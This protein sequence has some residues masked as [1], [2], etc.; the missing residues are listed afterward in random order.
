M[1][2]RDWDLHTSWLHSDSQCWYH[3]W[4]ILLSVPRITLRWS[5]SC[6]SGA[7]T[8]QFGNTPIQI[9]SRRFHSC[10]LTPIP[11]C[12]IIISL[13][14]FYFALLSPSFLTSP[15][16]NLPLPRLTTYFYLFLLNNTYNCLYK[17]QL[18][19]VR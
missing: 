19:A 16:E 11:I 4:W 1:V 9:S 7:S 8:Y 5:W 15:C 13:T 3:T 10:R 6:T 17:Y 2:G 18:R 14:F 12:T